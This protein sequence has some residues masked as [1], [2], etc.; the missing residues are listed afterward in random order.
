MSKSQP[1]CQGSFTFPHLLPHV[2]FDNLYSKEYFYVTERIPEYQSQRIPEYQSHSFL[3]S[4]AF[5][6]CFPT[7]E[8]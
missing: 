1:T 2:I 5:R 4:M 7:L 8:K 3:K 6:M